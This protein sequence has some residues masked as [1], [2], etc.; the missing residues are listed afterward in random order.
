MREP[1]IIIATGKRGVGK[2]HTT[3]HVI[4]K[5]IQAN[6]LKGK[7]PRKVLIFDVNMEWSDE[8]LKKKGC[9]YTAKPIAIKDLP[10]W[11]LQK[12]VEVRRVL[13]LDERGQPLGVD[14]LVDLLEDIL[15]YYRGGML[16]LEDI[17]KYLIDTRTAEI[18]GTLATNRHLN[19]D[20]Y[21][22]LQSLAPVTTRMWQ[23]CN[24]IR[25]HRQTD[26]I[27]RYKQ[28][29]PNDEI[30]LIAQKLVHLKYLKDERFYCYVDNDYNLIKGKDFDKRDFEKAVYSYLLENPSVINLAQKQF[31][32]KDKDA[33]NKAIV[34][35]IKERMPFYGNPN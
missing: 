26:D 31:D 23:N 30:Y 35:C 34:R 2:T 18:I 19:L 21:I 27:N 3:A 22:H 13:P 32:R 5:Y 16:V 9:N 10:N 6:P 14:K 29:I 4:E 15:A 17:N 1:K 24:V 25:F 11:T 8:E 28:R 12:R 7:K 33:Y 20:I